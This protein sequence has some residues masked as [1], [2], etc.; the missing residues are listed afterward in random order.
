MNDPELN[1]PTGR[2]HICRCH[3]IVNLPPIISLQGLLGYLQFLIALTREFG[4]WMGIFTSLILKDSLHPLKQ[5]HRS[6][7]MSFVVPPF[8]FL[9]LSSVFP[10]FF[11]A[12]WALARWQMAKPSS[13][14]S[15]TTSSYLLLLLLSLSPSLS[16]CVSLP[17]RAN[18]SECGRMS[19]TGL[20]CDGSCRWR[21]SHMGAGITALAGM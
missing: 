16:L 12:V 2:Q 14:S 15:T 8:Y 17:P 11:L 5:Q 10:P 9:P 4:R 13:S 3:L 1:I 20:S 6:T 7:M 21:A 19:I 18:L